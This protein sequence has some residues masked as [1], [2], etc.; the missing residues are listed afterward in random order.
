MLSGPPGTGVSTN[1]S[2]PKSGIDRTVGPVA[3]HGE[4]MWTHLGPDRPTNTILLSS[5]THQGIGAIDRR[6]RAADVCGRQPTGPEAGVQ[7][8][9]DAAECPNDKIEVV[10]VVG[11][12]PGVT[13]H[14]DPAIGQDRHPDEVILSAE[15]YR[16][17]KMTRP[18]PPKLGSSCPSA[19]WATWSRAR[20]RS[21][22]AAAHRLGAARAPPLCW[23]EDRGVGNCSWALWDIHFSYSVSLCNGAVFPR[24]IHGTAL[25]GAFKLRVVA[26]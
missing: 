10:G 5:C 23:L 26:I 25:P 16:R 7:A 13:S 3:H 19:A 11:T 18:S 22:A 4:P 2:I 9:V 14:R 24:S 8:P 1:P 6:L 17:P 21:A 20:V 15:R 12:C